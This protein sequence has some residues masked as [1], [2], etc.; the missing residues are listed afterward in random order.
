MAGGGRGLS[1]GWEQ[2]V[3]LA[4]SLCVWLLSYR[5]RS[6]LLC[7]QFSLLGAHGCPSLMDAV[8]PPFPKILSFCSFGWKSHLHC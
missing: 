5:T 7:P 1:P 6:S 4:A 8:P 2:G 3:P